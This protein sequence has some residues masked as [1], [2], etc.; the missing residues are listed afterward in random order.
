MGR[1]RRG[2]DRGARGLLTR[3]TV[4]RRRSG[5]AGEPGYHLAHPP[6]VAAVTAGHLGVGPSPQEAHM[7]VTTAVRTAQ[8]TVF[9]SSFTDGVLD[10]RR[11]QLGPVRD[12]GT[13]VASTAPG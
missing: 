1:G 3:P 11:E 5:R 2:G 9:V 7:S 8:R 10:P 6:V 12:G 4:P 13:I